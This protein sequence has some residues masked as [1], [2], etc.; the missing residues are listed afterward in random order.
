MKIHFLGTGAADW[1]QNEAN[2]SQDFR[3]FSSI[4][5]DDTLLIDPGPCIPEFMKT[6]DCP[7][8]LDNCKDILVTHSH[9]DHYSQATVDAL[10]QATLHSMKT[11]DVWEN[12]Q[13]I[14]YAYAAHHGTATD[15]VHF[16]IESKADGKKL[17]YGCDG[18]LFYYETAIALQKHKLDLMILDCTIG[19]IAG[20]YRIF[21]HNN[22]PMVVQMKETFRN[23][24]CCNR[25]MVSHMARTLHPITHKETADVLAQYDIE[26]AYDNMILEL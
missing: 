9:I 8:L 25:F 24:R 15:A 23:K 13:Y 19:D 11:G 5:I 18:S 1:K 21:E 12:D 6:F 2:A 26:T 4:L 16:V 22:I 10:P 14:V 20:D 3:R 17:F 7:S